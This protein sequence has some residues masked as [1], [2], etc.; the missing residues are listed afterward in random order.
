[1][2]IVF[3]G[4][5]DFAVPTLE[6]LIKA[7]HNISLVVTQTDKKQ[8][9]GKKVLAPP[10]KIKAIEHGIE[11]FQP[12]NVNS[13]ESVNKIVNS[14]PDIII[15]IAYGQILKEKILNLP[16]YGC[17]NVHAS[18]LPKY[19]GAA[20][21][22]WAII[23][24]EKKTG[25]T[26]MYMEKGLDTG[27]MILKKEIDIK[28]DDTAGVL[29]DK[30]MVMG[31]ETLLEAID[32]ISKGTNSITPQ[33]NEKSTYAPLMDKKLGHINWNEEATTIK[34]LI[35]GVTP[36]PG[37]YFIY[38]DQKVKIFDVEVIESSDCSNPG[39]VINVDGTGILVNTKNN[40]ILIK[41]IQFPSKK[42]VKV[43]EFL[44][45]NDFKVGTTLK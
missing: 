30:L 4:T 13:D 29:H 23:N 37:A 10:V 45:G 43:R 8:G 22:N 25:I 35:R 2:N 24:G 14:K 28:E 44:K 1:M 21:I 16:H 41:E 31:S 36:W 12:F 7:G 3:M 5:P 40:C 6:G 33:E 17:I 39:T 19:R 38:K 32:E 26:I 27:D 18:L 15:V 20:P 9:R 34:N 11:V 42:R